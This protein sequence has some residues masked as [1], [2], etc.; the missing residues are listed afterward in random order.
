MSICGEVINRDSTERSVLLLQEKTGW[1]QEE[2]LC[3][4]LDELRDDLKASCQT[5]SCNAPPAPHAL[6]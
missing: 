5:P 6:A 1:T 2:I 4:C 3:L